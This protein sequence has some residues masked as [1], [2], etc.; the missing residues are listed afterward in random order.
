MSD[1][2]EDKYK[3]PLIEDKYFSKLHTMLLTIGFARSGS[4][5]V[6]YLLTAHPNM[7]IAHEP[8]IRTLYKAGDII[9][10]LYGILFKNQQM[11]TRAVEAQKVEIDKIIP[12]S[13]E[14]KTKGSRRTEWYPIVPN[15][16]QNRCKSLEVA[17]V[18]ESARIAHLLV[19]GDTL[20]Q[21]T[22]LVKKKKMS[23]KF[24]FTVRN[25]YDMI[26]TRVREVMHSKRISE[27][28]KLS[29]SISVYE[30]HCVC[31]KNLLSRI[32]AKNVFINRHEDMV[33]DPKDQLTKL[34]RFLKVKASQDYLNDCMS[35]V[36]PTARESRY[37][38]DWLEE[39]KERV[40]K[41]SEDYD[42]FAGYSWSS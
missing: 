26:A 21:F 5:L 3:L 15:Q 13:N 25:P 34:C 11:Y 2:T 16:W 41:L 24:I 17:G 22:S 10:L 42:F 31:N 36:C 6:G 38:I 30:R 18:K 1:T 8:G 33:A 4:S 37:E 27:I 23:L 29:K 12:A 40:A 14:P 39:H 9:L 19:E 7:V 32:K 35:V 28:E 20:K